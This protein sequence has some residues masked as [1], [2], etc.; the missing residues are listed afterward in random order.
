MPWLNNAA[1]SFQVRLGE[2]KDLAELNWTAFF[3]D[4]FAGARTS[5]PGAPVHGATNGTAAV[6]VFSGPAA[7]LTRTL[8]SFTCINTDDVDHVIRLQVYDGVNTFDL[9]DEPTLLLVPV[10]ATL[11]YSQ[12]RGWFIAGGSPPILFTVQSPL[13]RTFTTVP[14][15]SLV[16]GGGSAGPRQFLSNTAAGELT[17]RSIANVDLPGPAKLVLS[18]NNY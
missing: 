12:K 7:G 5:E 8:V 6:A 18:L 1:H 13:S 15:I 2:A 11:C 10:N 17:N 3:K 14:E 16:I 4:T 9:V